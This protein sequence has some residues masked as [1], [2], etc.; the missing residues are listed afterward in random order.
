MQRSGFLLWWF[1][2]LENMSSNMG[3]VAVAHR[4]CWLRSMW[5]LPGPGIKPVFL[6]FAG[7]FLSPRA[8][9]KSTPLISKFYFLQVIHTER[10]D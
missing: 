5:G 9:V 8:L 4:L 3:S 2:L 1:F 7:R 6:A 10:V